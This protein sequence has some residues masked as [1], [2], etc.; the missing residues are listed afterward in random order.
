MSI[1]A[2]TDI[3]ICVLDLEQSR[4]FY[5]DGLGFSPVTTFAT[6]DPSTATLVDI[7]NVDLHCL[8]IERDDV[9]IEL[10]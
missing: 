2:L 8:F 6:S 5:C 7:E 1:Q 10:M 3:G 9:R 4:A